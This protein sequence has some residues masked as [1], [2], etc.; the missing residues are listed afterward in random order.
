MEGRLN[1]DEPVDYSIDGED[2]HLN[3]SLTDATVRMLRRFRTSLDAAGYDADTDTSW[4]VVWPPLPFSIRMKLPRI[5]RDP[6]RRLE[7]RVRR[8]FWRK[9]SHSS[10]SS[11]SSSSSERRERTAVGAKR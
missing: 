11:S 7:M 5:D 6:Q 9:D 8:V 1:L 2:G 10:S 4:V 3:F